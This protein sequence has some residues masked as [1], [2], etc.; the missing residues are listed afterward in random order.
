MKDE[1]EQK[2]IIDDLKVKMKITEAICE[3]MAKRPTASAS[4]IAKQLNDDGVTTAHRRTWTHQNVT[5]FIENFDFG[6]LEAKVNKRFRRESVKRLLK[7]IGKQMFD[8]RDHERAIFTVDNLI[9][10]GV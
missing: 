1:V 7:M 2:Y 6:E 9:A 5:R 10:Q 4:A 8:V 3:I